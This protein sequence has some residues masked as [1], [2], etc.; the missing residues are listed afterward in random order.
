LRRKR[1]RRHVTGSRR[2]DRPDVE[3]PNA[4]KS[5]AEGTVS[6]YAERAD[7][8]RDER[9]SIT[10]I[11]AKNSGSDQYPWGI[12]HSTKCKYHESIYHSSN[13]YPDS[14]RFNWLRN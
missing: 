2:M 5:I 9:T 12:Q 3:C 6:G 11:L 13:H 8:G 10:T 14:L 7:I 4:C 1:P